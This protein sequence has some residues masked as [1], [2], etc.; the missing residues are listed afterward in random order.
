VINENRIS[1]FFFIYATISQ[2]DFRFKEVNKVKIP[3]QLINN[4]VFIPIN[5]N[6]VELTFLLDSGVKETILFSL[7]EKNKLALKILKN[8]FRGVGSEDAIEGLKSVGI[9]SRWRMESI[10]HLLYIIVDQNFNISSPRWYSRKW[11]NS[12]S[13]FN[14]NLFEINMKKGSFIRITVEKKKE[15]IKVPITIEESKPYVNATTD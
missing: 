11:N 3:F 1:F 8:H 2:S 5:V 7:E 15:S 14:N 4:L 10:N 12:S 13:V 9:Y 6:G